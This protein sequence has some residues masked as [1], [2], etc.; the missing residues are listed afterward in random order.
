[1]FICLPSRIEQGDWQISRR[2]SEQSSR[3]GQRQEEG[4]LEQHT[5]PLQ[6]EQ[7]IWRWKSPASTADLRIGLNGFQLS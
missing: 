7:E 3:P 5:E 4:A 1:M 2:V 6:Q